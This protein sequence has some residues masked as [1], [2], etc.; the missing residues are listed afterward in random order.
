MPNTTESPPLAKAPPSQQKTAV[1]GGKFH[2]Y[3]FWAP[4]FWHGMTIG[5]WLRFAAAN[6]FRISPSRWPMAV[7]VT[8]VSLV[9]TVLWLLQKMI[10][11]RR[12][13][14]SRLEHAPVFIIGHWRSG[15]TY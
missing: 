6:G 4:R 1:P 11:S 9:N 10:F 8:L 13:E 14:Q 12:V 5:V 7:G 15:T 2:R 3:P